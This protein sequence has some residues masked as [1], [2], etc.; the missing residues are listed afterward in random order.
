MTRLCVLDT[1]TTGLDTS[2]DQFVELASLVFNYSDPGESTTMFEELANP[3]IP[4]P[5]E[6]KA[7]HHITEKDIQDA[8]PPA[9]VLLSMF[10]AMTPQSPVDYWVA[11][12]AP[13]DRGILALVNPAFQK[14]QW[15]DTVRCAKHIWPLAP[16]YSNQVL[17]YW[18]DLDLAHMLPPGL[19]P[20]RAL[21]DVI[22][23]TGILKEMLKVR[24]PAELYTLTN[25]PVL[26]EI[27]QLRKHKGLKWKNVPRDY[28]SWVVKQE[29][30]DSDV[31]HTAMYYL[32]SQGS[33]L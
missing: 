26:L 1:E 13:Y 16:G 30:M 22:V 31:R 32:N 5:V 29:D 21:Y 9:D 24:T 7:T 11:H 33:L 15:I 27:C 19:Y 10:Q 2:K 18:L 14:Y 6:A 8:R 12:N 3:G 17:R 20:H 4:I 25:T 28:L 23:T